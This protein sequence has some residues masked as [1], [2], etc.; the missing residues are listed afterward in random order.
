[1]KLKLLVTVISVSFLIGMLSLAFDLFPVQASNGGNLVVNGGFEEPVV[2]HVK[3]WDIYSTAEIPGWS[4]EWMPGPGMHDGYPR[5]VDAY[6]EL[7][8]EI[9]GAAADG[10]QYAELDA[11]WDGPPRIINFEPASIRIY[12]DLPT[13]PD[14]VYKLSFAFSPR[15]GVED[16]KLEVK[17]AG[18]VVAVLE[19]N[20]TMLSAVD[21]TYYQYVLTAT[22]TTTRLEFAD[23][24]ASDTLGT[25]LDD[26]SVTTL[27]GGKVTGGGYVCMHASFGFNAMWFSSRA[28]LQG[29]LN[30]V[31]HITGMHVHIHELT[32]LSVWE[33]LPGNKPWPLMKAI[34]G[35]P[36]TIDGEEGFFADV[37]VEDNGEPGTMDKFQ[38]TLSTG[39]VGGSDTVA[40]L[41]GNIQIHKPPK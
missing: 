33:D 20:G 25:F 19:A 17:W 13:V 11:D 41:V 1:M 31:D 12:Q 36:C 7:H 40:M 34:F 39:Y 26:I 5:P 32:Y 23:L 3:N 6:I 9:F 21:W 10:L 27:A 35:G 24:S 38:I 18:V 16:N 14:G 2:T 8:K 37:Y 28:K 4:V 30:Y 22:S 15:P 29:E